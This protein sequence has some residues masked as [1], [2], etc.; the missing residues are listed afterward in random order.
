MG[1]VAC[2]PHGADENRGGANVFGLGIPPP[3]AISARLHP[4]SRTRQKFQ[5]FSGKPRRTRVHWRCPLHLVERMKSRRRL[6]VQCKARES[7]RTGRRTPNVIDF[8]S[9]KAE[10]NSC[11]N[12][13]LLRVASPATVRKPRSM[14]EECHQSSVIQ[15][16]SPL[17]RASTSGGGTRPRRECR[18]VHHSLSEMRVMRRGKCSR[19]AS[20][21]GN[22]S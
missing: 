14:I 2:P 11:G 10:A 16:G 18:N 17:R 13:R 9:G 15:A 19:A 3:P 7:G 6:P 12:S 5:N 8:C 4:R 1:P 22:T 20:L 21:T